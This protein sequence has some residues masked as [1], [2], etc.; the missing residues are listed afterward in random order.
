MRILEK[1]R[2][3]QQHCARQPASTKFSKTINNNPLC[4]KSSRHS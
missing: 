4:H 3:I 1:S 2:Q